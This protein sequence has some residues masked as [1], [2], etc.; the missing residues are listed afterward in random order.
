MFFKK[1]K[2][3]EDRPEWRF[4]FVSTDRFLKDLDQALKDYPDVTVDVDRMVHL[5]PKRAT[6]GSMGYDFFAPF[7]FTLRPGEALMVPT[8]I[9]ALMPSMCG[10]LCFPRSSLGT[11]HGIRLANTV[12]VI[13][14][15][16]CEA[17]NEGHIMF[18]LVNGG[19]HDVTIERGQ[20]FMQGVITLYLTMDDDNT[21]TT[22][23]GGFGSTDK[24]TRN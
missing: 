6:K 15:D 22:R 18:K 14:S 8:G 16:Y 11:K 20:A 13:D 5:K 3:E 1:K 17:E 4:R 12:A 7:S 21:V 23:S 9:R 24:A 19:D 2:P 10:M